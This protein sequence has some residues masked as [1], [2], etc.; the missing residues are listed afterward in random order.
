MHNHARAQAR[1]ATACIDAWLLPHRRSITSGRML[2]GGLVVVADVAGT[3]TEL[4]L[5]H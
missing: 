2:L 4:A 1:G 3:E 5:K